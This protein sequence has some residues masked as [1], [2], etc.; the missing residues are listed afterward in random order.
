MTGDRERIRNEVKAVMMLIPPELVDEV[1]AD[2]YKFDNDLLYESVSKSIEEK[3]RKDEY[4]RKVRK[5]AEEAQ[6]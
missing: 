2:V 5:Q 1:L 4:A 3:K 6:K